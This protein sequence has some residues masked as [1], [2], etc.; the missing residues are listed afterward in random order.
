M[1]SYVKKSQ[2]FLLE[3]KSI[4]IMLKI[5]KNH[6]SQGTDI[7]WVRVV[8]MMSTECVGFFYKITHIYIYI[9]K[10]NCL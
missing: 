1:Y 7:P 3:K 6:R 4:K 5:L 2:L 9:Y 10:D 8:I